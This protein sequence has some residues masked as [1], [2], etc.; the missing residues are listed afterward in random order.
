MR[1]ILSRPELVP[2]VE[3]VPRKDD[4][5]DS[6]SHH[7]RF[8]EPV[9]KLPPFY[10][11]FLYLSGF[12]T[13]K[14]AVAAIW[15]VA[16]LFVACSSEPAAPPRQ[17]SN[18]TAADTPLPM[19]AAATDPSVVLRV[20]VSAIP[21]SLPTYDRH[22][23]KHWTDSDDDCQDAR[24]EVLVAESRNT[25]SYRTD[26]RCRVETGQWL[27]PYSNVVVTDPGKL[28]LTTWSRS[29]TPTSAARGHGRPSGGNA[30]PTTS[31]TLS[32]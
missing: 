19:T 21:E 10:P 4:A 8:K 12:Q 2:D 30:M 32:T 5:F 23:W 9:A 31:R 7:C 25:V 29:E 24:Q 28:D 1:I 16:I 15:T 3:H 22:D 17:V 6:H 14:L 20:T 27:A 11:Q 18:P 26:R 13:V